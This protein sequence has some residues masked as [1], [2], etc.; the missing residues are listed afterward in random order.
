MVRPPSF[1]IEPFLALGGE[2]F[3]RTIRVVFRSGWRV[4]ANRLDCMALY[5]RSDL[6]LF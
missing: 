2:S 4:V 3:L 1:L 5:S 6:G